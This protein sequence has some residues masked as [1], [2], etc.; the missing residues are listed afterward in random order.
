MYLNTIKT[1]YD[2]S[3][4]KIPFD[5]EKLKVLPL[6]S[7]TRQK[8]SFLQPLFNILLKILPKQ[9]TKRKASKLKRKSKII[10]ICR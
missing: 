6:R 5:G 4:A 7:R 2:K 3:R 9:A 8:M 1:I 10:S